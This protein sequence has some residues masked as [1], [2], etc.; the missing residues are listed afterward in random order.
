MLSAASTMTRTRRNS[1]A[2][3]R[4]AANASGR[5]AG[6]AGTGSR[7]LKRRLRARHARSRKCETS[8]GKLGSAKECFR[9]NGGASLGSSAPPRLRSSHLR[10]IVS[11]RSQSC[12]SAVDL[13]QPSTPVSTSVCGG[14]SERTCSSSVD[15]SSDLSTAR[16]PPGLS[17]CRGRPGA[18]NDEEKNSFAADSSACSRGNASCWAA[19]VSPSLSSSLIAV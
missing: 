10:S 19:S 8:R 5:S 15:M 11:T 14:P 4:N 6:S 7:M 1:A 12:A 2:C 18:S 13:P 9:M 3:S 16:I 17:T